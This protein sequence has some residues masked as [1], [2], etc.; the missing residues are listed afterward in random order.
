M[1]AIA[2][3]FSTRGI[4]RMARPSFRVELAHALPWAVLI[5]CV[6]GNIAGIV[7]KKTFDA[8][9]M[10]TSAIWSLPIVANVMNLFW[11]VV[12]RGKP[13]RRAYIM[14]AC[15]AALVVGSVALTPAAWARWGAVLFACQ[16]GLT[17]VFI[18]GL[19]TLRSTWWRANY[20][21]THRARITSRLHVL[22]FLVIT[23]VGIAATQLFDHDP[24]LYRYLYPAAAAIGLTSLLPLRS[25]R[26][27][28]ERRDRAQLHAAHAERRDAGLRSGGLVGGLHEIF[29]I[30]HTDTLF[31]NYMIAQFLLGSANFFTDAVLINVL[32]DTLN[33]S[34]FQSYLIMFLIPTGMMLLSMPRWAPYLDRVGVVQFRVTNSAMWIVSYVAVVS[35]VILLEFG[36]EYWFA[37]MVGLLVVGRV[38]N[39]LCRGGG[40][41]AW[42][43]GHLHFARSNQAELYMG[44]HVALTGLR[45]LVMPQIS[46]A[47]NTQVGNL[48]FLGSIVLAAGA[49]VMFTWL[50]RIDRAR[51]AEPVEPI[52]ESVA[53]RT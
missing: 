45:G 40:G 31:R 50:A 28:G 19:L 5:G 39:G 43:L 32:T 11:G 6:E 27:R 41:L 26:I 52:A 53:T 21:A 38:V 14:L 1:N 46:T 29:E 36:A 49:L 22:R 9:P 23:T 47:L 12:L 35:A 30:L 13:F 10:L 2:R 4:P 17:H 3:F 51:A 15:C 48:S 34:Y 33:C 7:A 42:T 25:L 24:L 16:V 8:S 37:L 20:P 18:S 44:I